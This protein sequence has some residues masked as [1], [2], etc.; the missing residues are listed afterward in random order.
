MCELVFFSFGETISFPAAKL[1]WIRWG[2]FAGCPGVLDHSQQ[3]NIP[4]YTGPAL[5]TVSWKDKAWQISAQTIVFRSGYH[6]TL[7]LL[8]YQD[9]IH[10]SIHPGL[11]CGHTWL[12]R[13]FKTLFPKTHSSFACGVLGHLLFLLLCF[14]RATCT[15]CI[16]QL[17]KNTMV[18]LLTCVSSLM[19]IASQL[20]ESDYSPLI[21]THS[22]SA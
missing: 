10:P 14:V 17:Q 4:S 18:G 20:S 3:I 15:S 16:L 6:W 2:S 19:F 1:D 13:V 5:T 9:T 7:G 22:N 11:L 8:F 21:A 12:G